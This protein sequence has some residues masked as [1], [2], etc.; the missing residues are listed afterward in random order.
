[1]SRRHLLRGKMTVVM[2][3]LRVEMPA[4]SSDSPIDVWWIVSGGDVLLQLAQFVKAHK[5]CA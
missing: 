5:V 1:M 3:C 4:V 2:P